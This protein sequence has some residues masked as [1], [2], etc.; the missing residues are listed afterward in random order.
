[1]RMICK[2]TRILQMA[3]KKQRISSKMT[4]SRMKKEG[5]TMRTENMIITTMK[6]AMVNISRTTTTM[7]KVM[8]SEISLFFATETGKFFPPIHPSL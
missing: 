5:K 6:M 4:A 3:T 8:T 7:K 2:L 1:M